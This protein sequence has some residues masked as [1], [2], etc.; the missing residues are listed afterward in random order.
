MRESTN[1]EKR[2]ADEFFNEQMKT[3]FHCEIAVTSV[4]GPLIV[5]YRNKKVIARVEEIS[6]EPVIIMMKGE[7]VLTLNEVDIIKDN[8][9]ESLNLHI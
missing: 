7:T 4:H 8:W 9:N 1:E 2:V 3:K 5:V 6:G